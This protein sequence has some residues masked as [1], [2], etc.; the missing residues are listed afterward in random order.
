M[1]ISAEIDA[2]G[3]EY[4]EGDLE[5]SFSTLQSSL[6]VAKTY[7]ELICGDQRATNV[8]GSCLS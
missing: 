7:E 4:A 1:F 8:T 5:S 3:E 2:G 6:G